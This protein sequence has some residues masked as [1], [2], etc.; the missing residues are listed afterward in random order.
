M[1]SLWIQVQCFLASCIAHQRTTEPS[2]EVT[3]SE[4]CLSR[5]RNAVVGSESRG[6]RWIVGISGQSLPVLMA[7]R[8][9]DVLWSD[10]HMGH[11]SRS[12]KS[13]DPFY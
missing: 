9:M 5:A 8:M 2:P 7:S 10:L 4:K 3:H 12:S 13:D 6:S 1:G 11:E